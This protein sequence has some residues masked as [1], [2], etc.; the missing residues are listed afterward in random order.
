M[1][2]YAYIRVSTQAQ[3]DD[4]LSLDAQ[5]RQVEGHAMIHGFEIAHIYTERAVSGAKPLDKRPEGRKLL[6]GAQRGDVV[7]CPKLDR[8]FRS[9]QDALAVAEQLQNRGVSLHLIDLGGDVTTSAVGKMFFTIVAAFAEFERDRIAERISDVKL[10]ER[11]KGRFLGGARPFG[12]QVD[13]EGNLIPDDAEQSA[14]GE[15]IR[16]RAEGRSY[17]EISCSV[18]TGPV[19]VSHATISRILKTHEPLSQPQV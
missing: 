16:L 12:Y 14:I 8:M 4:G 18:S 11:N 9:A 13:K 17:R 5:K 10:N 15:V 3:A 7:I 6:Q 19:R 1:A 2:T